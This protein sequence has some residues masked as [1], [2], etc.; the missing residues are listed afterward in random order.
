MV[1][2]ELVT[3]GQL[4]VHEQVGDLLEFGDRSH[5]ED[6][7]AAVMQ[8]VAGTADGAN[9]R[10]AGGYTGQGDRFLGLACNDGCVDGHRLGNSQGLRPANSWSSFCSY[11]W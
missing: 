11:A 1:G 2:G 3:R 7:V 4:A 9:R 5:V 8:V 6:V 10:V